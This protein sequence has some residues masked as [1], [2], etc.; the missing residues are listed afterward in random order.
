AF[1][2][3]HP[4]AKVKLAHV[5]FGSILG[6][7]GKPFKTRA[8]ETVKL[9]DLLDEAEERA[10]AV[11]TEKLREQKRELPEAQSRE[12]ARVVGIGVM[13]EALDIVGIETREEMQSF[14][15]V[16]VCWGGLTTCLFQTKATRCWSDQP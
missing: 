14:K 12:I 15:A 6:E 2:R 13:K 9:A 1:R 16:T 10:L 4:D 8:G 5:W 7:D 3:W 11:V